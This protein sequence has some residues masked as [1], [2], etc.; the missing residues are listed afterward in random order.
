MTTLVRSFRFHL[1]FW[2]KSNLKI[3]QDHKLELVTLSFFAVNEVK[4]AL[5]IAGRFST[6]TPSGQFNGNINNL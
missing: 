6:E 2:E 5:M 4:N 1:N 3:S